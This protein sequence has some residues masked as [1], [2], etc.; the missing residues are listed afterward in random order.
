M[1]RKSDR[2][3]NSLYVRISNSERKKLERMAREY[4]PRLSLSALVRMIL[5]DG[6][7]G[8]RKSRRK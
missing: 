5:S 1:K 8:V 4:Q 7:A 3:M 2:L 6:A